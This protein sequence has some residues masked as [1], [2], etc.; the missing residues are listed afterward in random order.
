MV[1]AMG[2]PL[3]LR[4][5]GWLQVFQQIWHA[6]PLLG[7]FHQSNLRFQANAVFVPA[8]QRVVTACELERHK[9]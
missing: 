8:R 1:F 5:R 7:T 9:A 6:L 2:I 4:G 3:S